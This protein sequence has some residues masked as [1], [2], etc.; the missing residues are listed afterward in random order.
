MKFSN[1]NSR[2]FNKF[3]DE[4]N[5]RYDLSE[6]NAFRGLFFMETVSWIWCEDE[7]YFIEIPLTIAFLDL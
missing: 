3:S 5:R 2:F 7:L 6:Y 1:S 4:I